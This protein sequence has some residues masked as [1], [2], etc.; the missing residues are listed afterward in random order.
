[1]AFRGFFGDDEQ[2]VLHT[3]VYGGLVRL[4]PGPRLL[5]RPSSSAEDTEAIITAAYARELPFAVLL[6]ALLYTAIRMDAALAV[7]W[8]AMAVDQ[9]FCDRL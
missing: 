3:A 4:S 2:S 9:Q 1:M 7:R 8:E 5:R 6:Q